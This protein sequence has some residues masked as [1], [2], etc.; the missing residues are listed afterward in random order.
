MTELA[1]RKQAPV[2]KRHIEGDLR[3]V[4]SQAGVWRQLRDVW[5]YRD[6]LGGLVRKELKVKYKDSILGFLWSLL[7]PALYLVIYFVAFQVVFRNGIP[8]FALYLIC[9]LLVWNF[10]SG[11]LGAATGAIV[12]NSSIVKKVAFPRVILPLASVGATFVHFLLQSIVL[13]G[14]LAFFHQ[15]PDLA[16]LA[17]VPVAIA[18]LVLLASAMGIFLSAVNVPF[19]D[20][21]HLV[22]L[23]LLAWFWSTPIVYRFVEIA[24]RLES[25][26][27]WSDLFFLN[28]VVA[29]VLTMQRAFYAE[30]DVANTNNGEPLTMLPSEGVLWYLERLGLVAVGALVLFF[31]ALKVFNRI[32]ERF[33]EEL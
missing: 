22:E 30:I 27:L 1:I 17:I 23:A 18:I 6:L 5:A 14:S 11:A 3:L 32:E 26:G 15:T 29:I 20:T 4:S 25:R 31:M 28:P 13:F 12:G 16:F 21:Q 33:A 8:R 7:N 19:R 9:G 2:E 24:P 10:F